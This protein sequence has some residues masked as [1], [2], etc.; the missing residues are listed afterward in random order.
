MQQ[1]A[2]A[3]RTRFTF[4]YS[5]REEEWLNDMAARGWHLSDVSPL[6]G[7]YKFVS[8][9][10][11]STLV[12]I[13]YRRLANGDELAHYRSLFADAGWHLVH[14]AHR[15]TGW[16]AQLFPQQYLVR[17]R[18]DADEDIFSDDL[19]R[20]SNHKRAAQWSS[21]GL[22]LLGPILCYVL[23]ACAGILTNPYHPFT[24][25]LTML[26]A[27]VYLLCFAGTLATHTTFHWRAYRRLTRP[28]NA[29]VT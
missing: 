28:I 12:R 13:D 27:T 21:C 23:V 7:R 1:T 6:W 18:A 10:P 3:T 20:A 16:T 15:G 2:E 9:E 4:F 22:G 17:T 8:G 5:Y 14:N 26:V 29:S 19:S 25:V 11:N 24:T